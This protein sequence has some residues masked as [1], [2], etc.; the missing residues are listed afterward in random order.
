MKEGRF[1]SF[2][3][4]LNIFKTVVLKNGTGKEASSL[5]PVFPGFRQVLAFC[6]A[7]FC[8]LRRVLSLYGHILKRLWY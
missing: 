8:H 7:G 1:E 6:A 4:E 5:N 2:F 3:A